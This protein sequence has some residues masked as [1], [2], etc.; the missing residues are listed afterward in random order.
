MLTRTLEGMSRPSTLYRRAR[1]GQLLLARTLATGAPVS[2]NGLA[3]LVGARR[4][5]RH[6]AGRARWR[7][8]ASCAAGVTPGPAG[9]PGGAHGARPRADACR[10]HRPGG[11]DRGVSWPTGGSDRADFGRLLGRFNEAIRSTYVAPSSSYRGPRQGVTERARCRRR[12]RCRRRSERARR[13]ASER[14]DLV[15]G[16]RASSSSSH[17]ARPTPTSNSLPSG[18]LGVERLRRAVVGRAHERAPLGEDSRRRASSARVS[19]SHA[20]W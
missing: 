14:P 2:I 18:I 11:S 4:H 12:P 3:E 15:A 19:T 17:A 10:P 20:R 6:P 7:R 9:E 16:P 5:D 1:S 13:P 8:R